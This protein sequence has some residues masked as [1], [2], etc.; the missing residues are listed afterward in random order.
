MQPRPRDYSFVGN[1]FALSLWVGLGATGLLASLRRG[2]SRLQPTGP[3]VRAACGTGLVLL[4]LA[5]PGHM[6]S[7]NYADHDRSGRQTARDLAYNMLTSVAKDSI[8]FTYGDN[9]TYPLWYLQNVE[10]VRPDVRVVNLSLLRTPWYIKQLKRRVNASAPVPFSYSKDEIE[11]LQYIQWSPKT[12]QIPV[13]KESLLSHQPALRKALDGSYSIEQPMMSWRI[14]GRTAGQNRRM[15]SVRDQVVYDI[16]RSNAD[17]GWERPVYFAVTTPPSS[18]LNLDPYLHLEGLAHR[19]VP[20]R[21]DQSPSRVVPGLSDAPFEE[22][23]L[24]NLADPNVHYG[25]TARG[26]AGLYYRV[27][28]SFAARRLAEQGHGNRARRLLNRFTAK[29]P[30]DVIPA[31]TSTRLQVAHAYQAADA[32]NRVRAIIRS[33][34]PLVLDDLRTASGRRAIGQALRQAGTLRSLYRTAEAA[35]ALHQFD[36]KLRP[37]LN[38]LPVSLPQEVRRQFGLPG[39]TS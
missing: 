2:L 29:V 36:D 19:V 37:V 17:Q 24:T 10:G 33:T 13:Q 21:H 26:T 5:V 1:F 4:V 22:F 14:Q 28:P 11:R 30:F 16:L 39:S 6:L 12:V 23:R 20:V 8:L 7:E 15:L 27:W 31:D 35:T 25:G 3:A 38:A 18:R 9:D 32:P 34:E